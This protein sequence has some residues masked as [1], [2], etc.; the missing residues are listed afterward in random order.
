MPIARGFS[1]ILSMTDNL[2][3]IEAPLL[4][5]VTDAVP[6][7]RQDAHLQAPLALWRHVLKHWDEGK[8][9]HRFQSHHLFMTPIIIK[10]HGGRWC[11]YPQRYQPKP[12]Q[13][14]AKEDLWILSCASCS[15]RIWQNET[16]VEVYDPLLCWQCSLLTVSMY[17]VILRLVILLSDPWPSRKMNSH[18]LIIE[19]LSTK[20]DTNRAAETVSMSSWAARRVRFRTQGLFVISSLRASS[21]IKE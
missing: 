12:H 13:Q 11:A 21:L 19:I 10:F 9:L 4:H 7:W 18:V 14:L 2:T 3:R 16:S 15:R 17:L 6:Q 5:S 1:R 20:D 8:S